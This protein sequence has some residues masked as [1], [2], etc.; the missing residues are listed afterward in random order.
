MFT[1]A[2]SVGDTCSWVPA[3]GDYK[4]QET[5]PAGCSV[6]DRQLTVEMHVLTVQCVSAQRLWNA[7][8]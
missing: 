1:C 7:H 8:G 3:Q 2:C 5:P 6:Q 4:H